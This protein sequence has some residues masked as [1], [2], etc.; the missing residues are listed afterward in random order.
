MQQNT[1]AAQPTVVYQGVSLMHLSCGHFL[2]QQLARH[3]R[4]RQSVLPSMD[5]TWR[6]T[7]SSSCC[8]SLQVSALPVEALSSSTPSV[9]ELREALHGNAPPSRPAGLMPLCHEGPAQLESSNLLL[10]ELSPPSR[11][12]HQAVHLQPSLSVLACVLALWST[13]NKSSSCHTWL[14]GL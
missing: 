12:K 5:Y 8:C 7:G 4:E 6:T 2:S 10:P 11:G 3:L 9:K 13:W 1:V 14:L